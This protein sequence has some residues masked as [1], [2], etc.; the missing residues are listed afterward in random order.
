MAVRK[1][2]KLWIGNGDL[3]S[4]TYSEV[5]SG[6]SA[7]LDVDGSD[8][9]VYIQIAGANSNLYI[10][11]NGTWV[12]LVNVAISATLPDNTSNFVW[13]S[14]PASLARF[15]KFNYGV[16][17]AAGQR[18]GELSATNDLT[19]AAVSEFGISLLGTDVGVTFDAQIN[20]ANVELLATT[21]NQG[22]SA[23]LRY[24]IRSWN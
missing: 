14:L 24:L 10:K 11:R 19:D 16:I 18:E 7:P 2:G 6:T 4:G 23:Q 20:G 5:S 3:N 15:I 17:R 12:G 1:V 8:G 13:L 21:D 22:V 9:D